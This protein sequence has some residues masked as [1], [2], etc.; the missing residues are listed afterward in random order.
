MLAEIESALP[1]A[2][3]I[4]LDHDLYRLKESDPDSGTGRRIPMRPG[5]CTTYSPPPA[6]RSNWCIT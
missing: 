5:E 1:G 3:L 4:S 2:R 6:G